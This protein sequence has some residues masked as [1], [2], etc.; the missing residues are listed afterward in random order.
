MKRGRLY[1][2]TDSCVP[3]RIREKCFAEFNALLVFSF[4]P[5]VS[6]VK[7]PQI[8]SRFTC[9]CLR[10]LTTVLVVCEYVSFAKSRQEKGCSSQAEKY[11]DKR[12]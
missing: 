7:I 8:F 1:L 5:V 10:W 11:T 12:F 3:M 9:N 2:P 4:V 6:D